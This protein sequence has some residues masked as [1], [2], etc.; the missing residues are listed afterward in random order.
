[1][2]KLMNNDPGNFEACQRGNVL[3]SY[4]TLNVK[5]WK[6]PCDLGNFAAVK[7]RYKF[8]RCTVILSDEQ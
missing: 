1:M 3:V 5:S 6:L 4:F 7:K 2:I 8:K